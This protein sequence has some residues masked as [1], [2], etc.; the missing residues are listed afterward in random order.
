MLRVEPEAED[1]LLQGED[2]PAGAGPPELERRAAAARQVA[3]AVAETHEVR[4]FLGGDVVHWV[5]GF[6]V[7][8]DVTEIYFF[9]NV[10][11]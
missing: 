2:A 8:V 10:W 9:V 11:V 5:P 4:E 7:H 1:L 6:A 3:P